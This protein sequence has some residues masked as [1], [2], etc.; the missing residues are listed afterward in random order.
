MA[1]ASRAGDEA[2]I[3]SFKPKSIAASDEAMATGPVAAARRLGPY[4]IGVSQ[5]WYS[6]NRPRTASK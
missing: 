3:A 4:S 6:G 2:R 1:E 5:C